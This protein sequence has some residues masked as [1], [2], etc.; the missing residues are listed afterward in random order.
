MGTDRVWA[1]LQDIS[2]GERGRQ[3]LTAV[4]RDGGFGVDGWMDGINQSINRIHASL[5]DRPG[6][7][8]N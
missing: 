4:D 7:R 5:N 8:E 2:K 1:E 6:I 3:G